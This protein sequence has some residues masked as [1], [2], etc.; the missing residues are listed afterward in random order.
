VGGVRSSRCARVCHTCACG[1]IL[2]EKRAKLPGI[3]GERASKLSTGRL[4]GLSWMVR[5]EQLLVA[6]DRRRARC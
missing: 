5:L 2:C 1:G 3:F 6:R 4:W